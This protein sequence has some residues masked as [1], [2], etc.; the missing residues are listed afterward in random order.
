M[1]DLFH[2]LLSVPI[3]FSLADALFAPAMVAVDPI[4]FFVKTC[5]RLKRVAGPANPSVL[6]GIGV[7]H[8]IT[9][10]SLKSR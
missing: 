1:L 7:G 10:S 9:L 4:L 8:K 6:S 3:A 2:F 5:P